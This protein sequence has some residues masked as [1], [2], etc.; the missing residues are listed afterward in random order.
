[1]RL[2]SAHG[3][4]I[5]VTTDKSGKFSVR[6]PPGRYAIIGGLKR[7]YDWPMGSCAGLSGAGAHFDPKKNSFFVVVAGGQSRHVVVICQAG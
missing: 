3:H 5:D 6:V 2:S 7:P 1:V 4:R